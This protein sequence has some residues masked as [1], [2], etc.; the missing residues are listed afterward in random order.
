M[1]QNE[2]RAMRAMPLRVRLSEGLGGTAFVAMRVGQLEHLLGLFELDDVALRI[3][4]VE[5]DVTAEVPRSGFRLE[6]TTSCLNCSADFRQTGDDKGWLEGGLFPR[7]RWL[8]DSDACGV[9][10]GNRVDDDLVA[11]TSKQIVGRVG[12][13]YFEAQRLL[14]ER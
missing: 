14:I 9:L 11:L 1:A 8:A 12:L 3:P 6:V 4:P 7:L 5:Y 2:M 10:A 13:V